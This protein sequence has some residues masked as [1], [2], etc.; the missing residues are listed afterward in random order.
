VIMLKVTGDKMC[1]IRS[2][3][4]WRT[5]MSFEPW[6]SHEELPLYDPDDP[7]L[8]KNILKPEP[9]DPPMTDWFLDHLNPEPVEAHAS[10]TPLP[11]HR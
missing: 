9:G 10:E 5:V 4:H 11:K 6:L 8:L 2:R 3:L 1:V 7:R